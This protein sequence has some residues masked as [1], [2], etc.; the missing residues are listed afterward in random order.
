MK[1][2]FVFII[3]ILSASACRTLHSV[4]TIE[5]QNS[6][7]LGNN[8]HNTFKVQLTNQGKNAVEIWHAPISGGNHS[9]L[10]VQPNQTVSVKVERNTALRIENKSNDTTDVK[11]RVRGDLGLSMGYKN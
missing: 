7:I 5:P 10:K 11:L 2:V 9:P 3:I 6:F 4:T 8:P 1:N